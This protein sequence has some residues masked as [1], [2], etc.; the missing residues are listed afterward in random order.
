MVVGEGGILE[1]WSSDEDVRA[2]NV[3][4]VGQEGYDA[5][6]AMYFA[7]AVILI[8][9]ISITLLIGSS[10][11]EQESEYEIKGF[12]RSYARLDRREEMKVEKVR[13]QR[14]L[15]EKQR[16]SSVLPGCSLAAAPAMI[17]AGVTGRLPQANDL[18]MSSRLHSPHHT[19]S[20]WMPSVPEEEGE[21]E[22]EAASMA[23]AIGC[24][25]YSVEHEAQL[26]TVKDT[27]LI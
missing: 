25:T 20:P 10:M 3:T 22:S 14:A 26:A 2:L 5:K 18:T 12:L 17:L 7:I 15:I 1:D 16:W 23:T 9:G 24:A 13:V 6:G 8:Y 27:T 21:G 19:L 4:S 11:R